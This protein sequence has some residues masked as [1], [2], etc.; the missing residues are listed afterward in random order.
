MGTIHE[1]EEQGPPEVAGFAREWE[2][3]L[4]CFIKTRLKN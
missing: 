3:S 2:R 1:V 4:G